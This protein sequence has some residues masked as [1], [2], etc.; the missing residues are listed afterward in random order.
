M[1]FMRLSKN[2]TLA[3]LTKTNTG[4]PNI[5]SDI[6]VERLRL[7]CDKVLQPLR[8]IYGSPII[9]NSGYR[10]QQVNKVVGG[11][12]T[13]QHCRGEAS[14]ITAGSRERNRRLFEIL[15]TMEFDQLIS[16]DYSFLHVSY[17]ICRENRKQILHK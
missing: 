14:D 6:E 7:L 4:I 9:V 3:E 15:K 12:P 10:S 1:K 16:Y 8:D 13:S 11:V 2:F 17:T 5:P